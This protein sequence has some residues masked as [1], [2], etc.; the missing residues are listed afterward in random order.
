V[1]ETD[2]GFD[3]YLV[4]DLCKG[5]SLYNYLQKK[6]AKPDKK[7][8][9]KAEEEDDFLGLGGLVAAVVGEEEKLS[10]IEEGDSYGM[11]EE[12]VKTVVLQIL[13][14]TNYLHKNLLVH[15]G[16]RIIK[17]RLTCFHLLQIRVFQLP[18]S[19]LN[20]FEASKC[21]VGGA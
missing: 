11:D 6:S 15:A 20:R 19:S 1:E 18:L 2:V 21:F 8:E 4:I 13:S 10:D 14:C 9:E 17:D 5:G 16:K 12:D 7:V 3:W